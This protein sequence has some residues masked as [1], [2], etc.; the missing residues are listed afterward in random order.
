MTMNRTLNLDTFNEI[1][2]QAIPEDKWLELLEHELEL[3]YA[4]KI[5][6]MEELVH[7]MNTDAPLDKIKQTLRGVNTINS[8]C[9]DLGEQIDALRKKEDGKTRE[10]LDSDTQS[11]GTTGKAA[12]P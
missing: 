6:K 7:L 11:R 12:E 2:R 3:A 8:N 9:D 1:L 4:M 5:E 10:E